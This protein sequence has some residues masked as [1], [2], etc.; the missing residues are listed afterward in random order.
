[1]GDCG[2]VSRL[3]R[4]IG[5]G[6]IAK[7]LNI[8]IFDAVGIATNDPGNLKLLVGSGTTQVSVDGRED[9]GDLFHVYIITRSKIKNPLRRVLFILLLKE[10]EVQVV[11]SA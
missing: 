9:F 1:M 10:P 4:V 11:S 5:I 7:D 3:E 6:S 8:G 2:F